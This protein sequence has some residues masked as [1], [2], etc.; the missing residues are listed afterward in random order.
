MGVLEV[1]FF[2]HPPIRLIKSFTDYVKI[3]Y[4]VDCKEWL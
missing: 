3:E 2:L 4:K 1:F